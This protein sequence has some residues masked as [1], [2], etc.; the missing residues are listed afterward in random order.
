MKDT[1]SI[2]WGQGGAPTIL[3]TKI[4]TSRNIGCALKHFVIGRQLWTEAL[5][6][7]PPDSNPWLAATFLHP[8]LRIVGWRQKPLVESSVACAAFT[9]QG[10]LPPIHHPPP[11]PWSL[12][13]RRYSS[14]LR[15][16]KETQIA[17]A[18]TFAQSIAAIHWGAEPP[19]YRPSL[20]LELVYFAFDSL[21]RCPLLVLGF[22]AIVQKV[23]VQ[24]CCSPSALLA[25]QAKGD[26]PC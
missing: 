18:G 20:A 5:V 21:L 9:R 13:R 8:P 25:R 12:Y 4:P 24:T 26:Y 2:H 19:P 15:V 23:T 22:R 11:T 1:K 3:E 14:K 7:L 16:Q 6:V 10:S 17:R